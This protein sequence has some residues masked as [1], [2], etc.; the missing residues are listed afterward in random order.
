MTA[1][2]VGCHLPVFGPAATRETLVGFARRAEALGYDSLWVSDH[3][4]IPWRIESRYPYNATGDFPLPPPTNLL[5][6]L[7][8]LALVAGVTE[9]VSLG[10]SV[11]V[12]PHRHPVLAAKMLATLDHLAPGRVILGAGVGWMR[13][14]I[15]LFGVPHARRGAWSDEA[16][17]IMRACWR[18]ERASFKGEFYS[19]EPLAVRPAPARGTIPI[20]IGGHSPRALRRVV[21]LGD[22]WHAAFPT[23]AA[24][25]EGIG[26]LRAECQ[27]A[28]RSPESLTISARVGLAGRRPSE[29]ILAEI[30]ALRDLGVHHVILE[31]AARE[32]P[33][34]T[35]AI[36]RFAQEVRGRL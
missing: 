9:R 29:E 30:R 15:E 2:K 31:P 14:E 16:I 11:L 26:K 23:P 24:L 19:F 8:A 12:L 4:V 17:R 20:W 10:T 22:G 1:I 21:A 18:D 3:V 25:G 27:R 33:I 28:G 6:P 36:E 34:M 7:T 5:E 13:E 35:A 32:L